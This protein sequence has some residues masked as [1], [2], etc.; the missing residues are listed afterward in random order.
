[1][2]LLQC[3]DIGADI[4]RPDRGQRQAATVALG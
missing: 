2:G 3:L 4:V 1:V